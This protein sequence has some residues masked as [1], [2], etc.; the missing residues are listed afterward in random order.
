VREERKQAGLSPAAAPEPRGREPRGREPRGREPRAPEPP[1]PEPEAKG[2]SKNA[3]RKETELE[4]AVEDAEAALAQLEEELADPAC[5]ATKY[6][7]AKSEARHTAA[8]RAVEAA[9]AALEEHVAKFT[10]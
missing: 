10:A 7:A 5:W 4:K 8:R 3:L 2:P 9:Y 1:E 6:E